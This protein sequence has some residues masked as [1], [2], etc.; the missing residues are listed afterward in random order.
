MK[1][2][3]A[4]AKMLDEWTSSGVVKCASLLVLHR[5][6]EVI[7]H[8]AGLCRFI[9]EQRQVS[10]ETLFTI[11]SIT[12]TL[13]ASCFMQ[14]VEEGVL[15][16]HEPVAKF[17]PEFGRAGKETITFFHLL[18]HTSGLP[19]QVAGKDELRARE[20]G[21]DEFNERIYDQ[22]PLSE[23]GTT[24]QYSNCAFSI[25]AKVVET[26]EGAP[27][28]AVLHDRI[29]EPLGMTDSVL[30]AGP[31]WDGRI[32][33]IELPAGLEAE[34]CFLNNRYWRGMGAPWGAMVSNT[35]D[36]ATFAEAVRLGGGC[37]LSPA[38]VAA[39]T[40]DRLASLPAFAG[41]GGEVRQGLGWRM[42]PTVP[43]PPCGDLVSANVFCHGG[44]TGT[45]L[46][47]DPEREITF[48]FLG[49]KEGSLPGELFARLS[50][51]AVAAAT[52]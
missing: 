4:A 40:T 21:L 18:T 15:S 6:R 44:A 32:A 46:W 23:P 42:Q 16:L 26:L 38:T 2:P 14:F 49:N 48:V 39:M 51:I 8:Q 17:L 28:G 12:K 25:L 10:D 52:S 13:T 24:F 29:F 22:A 36:L 50:N 27:F 43:G 37:V 35:R 30:A 5:G 33:D 47:V 20:G 19:E 1:G 45:L 34:R 41:R 7:R 3:D 11:A 31:E 9:H